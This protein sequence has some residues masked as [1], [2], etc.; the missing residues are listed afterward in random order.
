MFT[1]NPVNL[2]NSYLFF[3]KE[4]PPV[5][6]FEYDKQEHHTGLN[7]KYLSLFLY[8]KKKPLEEFDRY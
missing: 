2:I 3:T 6:L 7:L 8:T 4:S 5:H 1:I